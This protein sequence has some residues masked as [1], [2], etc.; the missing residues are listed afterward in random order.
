MD[1]KHP[2]SA[3]VKR[4]EVKCEDL[5]EF[6]VELD[7]EKEQLERALVEV[8]YEGYIKK[9]EEDILRI[10]KFETKKIPTTI[11]FEQLKGM[12]NESI[13]KLKEY[14]PATIFDAK[15]IAGI[16]PADLMILIAYIEQGNRV[17]R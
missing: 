13:E 12:R 17:K 14:K 5:E 16:N 9:Q 4:P 6:R 15:K 3:V 1:I 11:N 2:L 10:K 8:K 7:V